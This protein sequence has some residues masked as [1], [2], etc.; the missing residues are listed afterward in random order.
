MKQAED[1]MSATDTQ[2]DLTETVRHQLKSQTVEN[3]AL[4]RLQ[5]NLAG[6]ASP[7]Q[8][9]TSYDRMHHRHNRS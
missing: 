2:I 6:E 9:I 8:V 1:L 4:L 3:P 5:S 7:D